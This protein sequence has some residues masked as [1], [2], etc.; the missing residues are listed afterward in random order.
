MTAAWYEDFKSKKLLSIGIHSKVQLPTHC[1]FFEMGTKIATCKA[2][3]KM[4]VTAHI[5]HPKETG[6]AQLPPVP[7]SRQHNQKGSEDSKI[8]S[9]ECSPMH[10]L[11]WDHRQGLQR[12][13]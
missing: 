13:G 1:N 8:G 12:E 6:H 7:L 3:E 10:H 2:W 5:L 4:Y 11:A 9:T